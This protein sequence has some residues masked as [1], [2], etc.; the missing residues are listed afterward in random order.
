MDQRTKAFLMCISTITEVSHNDQEE[1]T[2]S[3]D[4]CGGELIQ[5]DALT[6]LCTRCGAEYPIK[7]GI[8]QVLP[9]GVHESSYLDDEVIQKY[10]E[11]HFGAYISGPDMEARLSFPQPNLVRDTRTDPPI[12]GFADVRLQREDRS[13]ELQIFYQSLAQL[14]ENSHLTEDFY[15]YM[16][17]LSRPLLN[18]SSLVLDVGCGLGRITAEI[19]TL[20]AAYVIG[21]DRS[22]QMIE[23]AARI[24]GMKGSVPIN[25]NLVGDKT[26]SAHLTTNYYLDNVDFLVGDV[27]QLP[28]RGE[29]F[30]L[31]LSLNLLDRVPDPQRAMAEIARVL[32]PGGHLIV[33]H[34]YQWDDSHAERKYWVADRTMLFDPRLW[35]REQEVDGIPFVMRGDSRRITIYFNHC[36]VYRKL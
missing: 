1:G 31:A 11:M 27:E 30:D 15:Q 10:Y 2:Q 9:K 24:V 29:V 26:I 19:G 28:I 14:M 36:L 12:K 4:I 8:P 20:G 34:P 3:S 22:P 35:K 23:E 21:L 6:L 13:E 7:S 17:E 5:R 25:L 18:A 33:I 16:L 32:K